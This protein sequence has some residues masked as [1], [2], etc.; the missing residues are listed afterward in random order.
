[1]SNLFL[2]RFIT[3]LLSCSFPE[4]HKKSNLSLTSK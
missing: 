1:M 2:K 3:W 4:E